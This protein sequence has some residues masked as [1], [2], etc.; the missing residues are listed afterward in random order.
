MELFERVLGYVANLIQ[1]GSFLVVLFLL[2]RNSRRLARRLRELEQQ[3]SERPIALAIGLGGGITEPVKGFLGRQGLDMPVESYTREGYVQLKEFPTI[4][5]DLQQIKDRLTEQGV[6]EVHLFY[7]GPVTLAMALGAIT[8]NWVPI[9]VYGLEAEGYRLHLV[10]LKETV[11][12]RE[13]WLTRAFSPH[14]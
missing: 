14:G 10:L 3:T 4:L 13:D 5:R 2:W 1:V 8:D 9:K 11:V 7:K 6:T 12:G